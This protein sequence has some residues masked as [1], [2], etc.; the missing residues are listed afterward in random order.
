MRA[1]LRANPIKN[2]KPRPYRAG[3]LSLWGG[4][5]LATRHKS[6]PRWLHSGYM[7]PRN[8]KASEVIRG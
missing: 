2:L 7:K 4:Y 6:P 3:A 8:N 1:A 5:M